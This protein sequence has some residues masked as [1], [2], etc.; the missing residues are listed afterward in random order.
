M[1]QSYKPDYSEYERLR[2]ILDSLEM[3][4]ISYYREGCDPEQKR[5]RYEEL[6]SE[7]RPIIKR[8]WAQQESLAAPGNCPY[9]YHDCDG[10]CVPYPC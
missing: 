2:T 8:L 3:G 6:D 7:L 5:K 10:V 4:A 1:E 9:G